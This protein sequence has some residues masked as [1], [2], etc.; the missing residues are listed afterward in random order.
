MPR[1]IVFDLMGTLLDLRAL[2]PYF[3]RFFGDAAVQREWFAQTLQLAMAALLTNAYE[4]FRVQA[5]TAL[6]MTARRY[7]VSLLGE[8]KNLLLITLLKLRPY[9][10]VAQGL[11]RLRDAGLRHRVDQ[12]RD[13]AAQSR[14]RGEVA[15]LAVVETVA[16]CIDLNPGERRD[17]RRRIFEMRSLSPHE[18]L[19]RL[20]DLPTYRRL[21]PRERRMLD[22]FFFSEQKRPALPVPPGQDAKPPRPG[23]PSRPVW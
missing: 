2:D 18:R 7:K 19:D 13:A 11:Q 6:E 12:V 3:E 10:E 8:E 21:D 22:D 16:G 20:R 23:D 5:D 4:D 15:A 17:V 14:G 9:P 1:V